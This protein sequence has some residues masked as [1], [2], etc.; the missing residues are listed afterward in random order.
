MIDTHKTGE[1]RY[2]VSD[3]R[4]QDEAGFGITPSQTVG[5]YVH[6]GLTRE[7]S[8]IIAPEG[9]ADTVDVTFT[10]LD[11]NGD[12]V[13]DA[14]IEIWQTG[15][16]G[17]YNTEE[18]EGFR[19]L[20][21]GMCDDTG[22]VTFTTVLPGAAGEEAPHLKVGV[23]A[24]GMLERLYTR[25][26]FPA[27]DNSADPVLQLVDAPRRDLLLA[28][29]VDGGFRKTIVMQHEDPEKETPF[30]RV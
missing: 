2:E 10:V 6:I 28:E 22:S 24:R 20:G 18:A 1:F 5:P 17:T 15:P 13:A 26:Y 4:D 9:T 25:L 12:P 3:I 16:D 21:R 7:G 30:F 8:E 29:P 14:M 19:G 23:F 27:N 11:G